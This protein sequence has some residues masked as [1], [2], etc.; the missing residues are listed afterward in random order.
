MKSYILIGLCLIMLAGCSTATQNKIK[1]NPP[2]DISAGDQDDFDLLDE[3]LTGKTVTIEDPIEGFNRLM[4]NANDGLYYWV[5][6]PAA[7]GYSAVI[8]EPG[9]I[10]I[11][12][13]FQNLTTPVRFVN[14]VLQGKFHSAGNEI[15]RFVINTT[16]GVAGFFDPALEHGKIEPA[17]EDFGQTLAV[18]GLE[19]GFYIVWPLFGPSTLRDSAGMGGDYFLNPVYYLE[20]TEAKIAVSAVRITNKTSLSIGE[21]ETFKEA[22]LDPYIAMRNAYIQYRTKQIK[23]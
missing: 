18:Y 1:S 4:F 2:V 13:F 14:C 22:S 15:N 20:D 12:N 21:Y 7:Q 17:D 9:R 23:E 16:W 5:L 3:E 6:K 11:G 10:G 19:D 8:P